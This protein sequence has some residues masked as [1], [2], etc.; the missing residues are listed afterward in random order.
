VILIVTPNPA[1]DVTYRVA[2]QRV[3]TTQR[4]LDVARRP[5]GKGLN[6]GRVLD[7]VGIP[8]RAVLPLGAAAGRWIA[9]GLDAL[10]LA[11]VDIAVTGE[12]R[13]TVTVVDDVEHPTMFGEPGPEVTTDEWIAVT[14]V[15]GQQLDGDVEFLVV[16]GSLPHRADPGVVADW[17]AAARMRGVPS[18]VDCPGGALL[19]AAD[20]GAT[21]CKPNRDELLEA[22]GADDERSGALQLLDRGAGTVVVSRGADGLAAHT[23]TGVTEVRAVPGVSGNPTGAGDA[24]TA[25]L[26][27]ALLRGSADGPTSPTTP[28]P[29]PS[30]PRVDHAALRSAA[31]FGAA[32][33]L[34]PVAGEVDVDAVRRFLA[35]DDGARSGTRPSDPTWSHA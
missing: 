20:A 33:V 1:V 35:D 21:I 15:I 13:T 8:S 11:H 5:G 16:S 30:T 19:A 31:A 14:D 23:R 34:R 9:D 17:V 32:A 25:G 2:R 4:V 6:V 28:T 24:A 29:T 27:A 22:T 18:L 3:G 10:G 26:L 12:T 7:A